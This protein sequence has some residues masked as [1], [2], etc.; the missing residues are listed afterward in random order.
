MEG[1]YQHAHDGD[2]R[3]HLAEPPEPEEESSE[4][5]GE[6]LMFTMCA[7]VG[8]EMTSRGDL[9]SP[10]STGEQGGGCLG[11]IVIDPFAMNTL[12]Y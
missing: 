11:L 8:V 9:P 10:R 12:S 7:I 5:G 1:T 6:D 2:Q 4:H 3:Y